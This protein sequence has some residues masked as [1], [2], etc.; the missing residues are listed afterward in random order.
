MNQLKL[1]AVAP[2]KKTTQIATTAPTA[3][4]PT[5]IGFHP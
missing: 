1:A 4:A 2:A 5:A 3:V